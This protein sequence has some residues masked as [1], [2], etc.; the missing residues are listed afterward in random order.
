MRWIVWTF[1]LS[2]LS[3]GVSIKVSCK[4]NFRLWC[5]MSSAEPW[6]R[7]R[8][9]FPSQVCQKWHLSFMS[10]GFAK[11]R[12]LEHSSRCN[13]FF[14]FVLKFHWRQEDGLCRGQTHPAKI[15]NTEDKK[16]DKEGCIKRWQAT[17]SCKIHI[18]YNKKH[19]YGKI[20]AEFKRLQRGQNYLVHANLTG[21]NKNEAVGWLGEQ[22]CT[23]DLNGRPKLMPILW[24]SAT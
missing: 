10:K 11:R 17:S 22:V 4:P 14:L 21:T 15:G 3:C 24:E 1:S 20:A 2:W 5:M 19:Y 16:T 8:R 23:T 9:F 6:S 7:F 18:S 13:Y 12:K